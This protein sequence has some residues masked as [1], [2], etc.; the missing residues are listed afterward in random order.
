MEKPRLGWI[1]DLP[2]IRD[3]HPEHEEVA[4]I[5]TK[6]ASLA[7]AATTPPASVDLRQWCSPVED[8]GQLGS[9]TANAA[10]GLI[11]YFERRTTGKYLDASRLFVYKTTRRLSGD[12]GDTGAELRTTMQA[13]VMFGAPPE[14]MWPYNISKFDVEPDAFLYSLASNFKATT[15]YRHDPAGGTPT[16]TLASIK[17]GLAG[18]L[19]AMFGS[20]VYS[21]M[22]GLGANDDHTGNI[23]FPTNSDKAQGGHAMVVVGYDDNRKIGPD[24][25]ALLIRNSWGA[26]WGTGGYGWMPYKYVT[27][28]LA[29]DFWSIVRASFIDTDLFA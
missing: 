1:R 15:Y 5:L 21:S 6:S 9:C 24:T 10:V 25:G 26:G 7:R 28:G 19:P 22:P 14:K 23:P 3:F 4:S 11:E 8:Q 13:I 16:N 20:T 18:G 27:A 17:R 29:N 2:D 12:T